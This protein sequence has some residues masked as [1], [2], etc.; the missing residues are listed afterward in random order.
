MIKARVFTNLDPKFPGWSKNWTVG[1]S[2]MPVV[3]QTFIWY[4]WR[5]RIIDVGWEPFITMRNMNGEPE[6]MLVVEFNK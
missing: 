1:F 3:G 2:A 6:M 4:E 5:C